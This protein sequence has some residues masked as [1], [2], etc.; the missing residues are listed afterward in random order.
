[1]STTHAKY[2][3]GRRTNRPP[4]QR[5]ARVKTVRYIVKRLGGLQPVEPELRA[6]LF[7][8]VAKVQVLPPNGGAK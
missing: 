7:D 1:M 8:A 6:A 4:T 5:A 3:D 2:S